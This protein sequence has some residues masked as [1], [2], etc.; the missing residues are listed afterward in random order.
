[1]R[2]PIAVA[3]K[4][5]EV[6]KGTDDQYVTPMQLIKL[7]Y[8]CHGWM[9]GLVG[10]PLLNE[11]VQAWR[12]GPVV[13]SIYDAVKK[14]KDQPVPFP[15]TTIFGGTPTDNFDA[16]DISIIQQV[17]NIYGHRDGVSLSALTHQQGTPW[18]ITW[19]QHG[20]NAVI[21]NDLI[22]NHYRRLS[23]PS[24]HANTENNKAAAAN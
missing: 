1:M 20:Q 22:E 5:L 6:A 23:E 7:T 24:D 17:Y 2:N 11:S 8:L 3:N 9:L 13:K 15:I 16:T 12:Y 21:S 14:Y 4:I 10:R 18:A 19:D